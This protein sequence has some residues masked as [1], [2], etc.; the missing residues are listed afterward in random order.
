MVQNVPSVPIFW[1]HGDVDTEIPFPFALNSLEFL[2]RRLGMTGSKLTF[3]QYPGLG[4][5][6]SKAELDDL[7]R[8]ILAKLNAT[9]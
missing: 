7:V 1:A 3:L 9:S 8:W 5:T 2:Q 6:T 4:H